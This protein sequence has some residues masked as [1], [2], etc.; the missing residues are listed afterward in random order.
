M[1]DDNPSCPVTPGRQVIEFEIDPT[2]LFTN[3]FRMIHYDLVGTDHKVN[4]MAIVLESR[5]RTLSKYVFFS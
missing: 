5:W 1:C 4:A 3:L 2:K